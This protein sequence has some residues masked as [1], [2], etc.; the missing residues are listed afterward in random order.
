MIN[1]VVVVVGEVDRVE[2]E[3]EAD[4]VNQAAAEVQAAGE[5]KVDR[6]AAGEIKEAKED[7]EDGEATEAVRAE[8]VKED[9][10]AIEEVRAA[11]KEAGEVTEE[12]K[13]AVKEDGEVIGEARAAA[14]EDG[15][16]TEEAKV[17]AKEDGAA[18]K[19]EIEDKA[20]G[21]VI[22]D[23]EDKEDNQAAVGEAIDNH[24]EAG[25]DLA[26][27]EVPEAAGVVDQDGEAEDGEVGEVGRG[28]VEEDL[29]VSQSLWIF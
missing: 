10:V 6:A 7:G 27:L 15:V 25:E 22:E 16:V 20:A 11:A 18:A 23:K 12:A 9:G 28:G 29:E 19:E 4:R 1:K 17:A 13:V 21:E 5:V 24:K 2:A 8:V 3:D 26:V 14:K